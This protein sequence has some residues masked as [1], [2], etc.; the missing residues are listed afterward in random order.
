M[1]FIVQSLSHVQLLATPWT[2]AHQVSLSS[3]I[4]WSLLKLM[5]IEMVMP[6]NHFILCHPLLLLPSIF[7]SM[8]VFSMSQL[9]ASGGQSIGASVSAPVLPMNI[10]GWFSLGLTGLVSLLS[11]GLSRVFSNNTVQKHWFFSIHLYS[12]LSHPYMTTG[13]TIAL[14][15]RGS[16]ICK[17]IMI[18]FH[19]TSYF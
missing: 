6:S 9:F 2:A 7:P 5:S 3:T 18:I 1:L 11:K 16:K 10:Q 15:R 17:V 4:C 8:R 14:T 12:K 19:V 13:K